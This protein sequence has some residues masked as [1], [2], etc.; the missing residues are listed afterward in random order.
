MIGISMIKTPINIGKNEKPEDMAEVASLRSNIYSLLA[1]IYQREPDA[2]LLRQIRAPQFQEVLSNLGFHFEDEFLNLPEEKLIDNLAIEYTRLFLGP[3][4]HISPHES[5]HLRTEEGGGL[6]WG[7]ATGKVKNFIESSGFEYKADYSGMPDHISVELEFMQE[8]SRQ[9]A[10]AWETDDEKK[11]LYCRKIE[12]QFIEENL[13]LWVPLFCEKIIKDAELSFY[14][15]IA[16]LT[17]C[18]IEFESKEVRGEKR[19][20]GND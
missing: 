5:V 2:V 1:L 17:Q 8:V 7:A 6:L 4:K 16:R 12:K 11:A 20:I 19:C 18:F 15:E 13:V 9:E 14:E 10:L 3:G